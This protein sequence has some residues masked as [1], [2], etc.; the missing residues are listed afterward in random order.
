MSFSQKVKNELAR[1]LSPRK[2]CQLAELAGLIRMDGTVQIR[3]KEDIGILVSTENAAVARK[4]FTLTKK[5]FKIR[6]EIV[7]RRGVRPRKNNTYMVKIFSQPEVK[8]LLQILGIDGET[9]GLGSDYWNPKVAKD[10]CCSKAYLRGIF[11]GG[12]SVSDPEG[13]YH[14]EIVT[15]DEFHARKIK[16]IISRFNLQPKVARR[17]EWYVIYFKESEQIIG[18]L[19]VVGAYSALLKFEDVR[20]R[21]DMRNRVNRLVNCE[22]ANLNKTINASLRQLENINYIQQA[23]GLESLPRSLREIAELRL[24]YPDISL[25]ELGQLLTPPVGKSG[26]NHRMRKLEKIAEELRK[27]SWQQK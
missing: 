17:K 21:K 14:L 13:N 27:G 24:R 20:I 6:A 25:K 12:G 16:D 2:C 7:V 19:N 10:F 26:V 18:F 15:A 9:G 22:T 1:K 11:L 23:V 8:A 5:L 4:I 3:G